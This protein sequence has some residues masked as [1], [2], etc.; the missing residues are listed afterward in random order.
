MFYRLLYYGIARKLPK[1]T[2][3]FLG[4][5]GR[6]LRRRC[7]RKLFAACGSDLIVE[8]GAYF[9]SGK[10]MRVGSYVGIGKNFTLHNCILTIDDYLKTKNIFTYRWRRVDWGSCADSPRMSQ[11]WTW[12]DSRRRCSGNQRCSRLCSGRRQSGK[13]Y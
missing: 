2:V 10:D 7:C 3:P 9:G 13:N 12:S 4:K 8:Q 11:N 5:I 1:S 6:A